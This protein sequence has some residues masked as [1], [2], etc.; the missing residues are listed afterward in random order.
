MSVTEVPAHS[1]TH[2]WF[3]RVKWSRYAVCDYHQTGYLFW[4]GSKKKPLALL[5]DYLVCGWLLLVSMASWSDRMEGAVVRGLVQSV[6]IQL[7]NEA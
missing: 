5:L 3:L 2:I 4:T 7:P 1:V 6:L